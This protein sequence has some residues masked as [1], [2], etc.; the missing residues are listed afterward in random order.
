MRRETVHFPRIAGD[1]MLV[2]SYP[3]WRRGLAIAGVVVAEV[4]LAAGCGAEGS[5][6]KR[7][8]KYQ[9]GSNLARAQDAIRAENW[10]DAHIS[11]D[12]ARLA[13]SSDPTQFS[14]TEIGY[15]QRQIDCEESRFWRA[16]EHAAEPTSAE[17][18]RSIEQ[19]IREERRVPE[20]HGVISDFTRIMRR[21]MEEGRYNDA[22]Q[23]ADQI[24]LLSPDDREAAAVAEIVH[25]GLGIRGAEGEDMPLRISNA[26]NDPA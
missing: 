2:L 23:I 5:P 24:L 15:F 16:Q 11:L 17:V 18:R 7:E 12:R 13:V 22:G 25:E 1:E 14:A 10:A 21:A 8:I 9:I 3:R 6:Q 4:L 19:R 20:S 26:G